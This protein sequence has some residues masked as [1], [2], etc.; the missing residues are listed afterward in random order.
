LAPGEMSLHHLLII[1]GSQVNPSR[2]RRCG[3]AIRYI[4]THLTKLRGPRGTA[5]LVRGRDHGNFDLEQ[6]PEGEFHPAAVSRYTAITRSW[7]RGVFDEMKLRNTEGD[8]A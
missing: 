4:P 2:Q 8:G 6:A 1:H 7:M 5:T 3:L